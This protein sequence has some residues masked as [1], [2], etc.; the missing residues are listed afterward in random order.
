MKSKLKKEVKK[1]L[2]PVKDAAVMLSRSYSGMM[3]LIHTGK[4]PYVRFDKPIYVD[5]NDLDKFIEQ[6]KGR[7]TY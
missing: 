6:N 3:G 2:I 7:F 1:R 5:I 4:L